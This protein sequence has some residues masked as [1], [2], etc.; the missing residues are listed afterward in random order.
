M[1][2]CAHHV[3]A[4]GHPDAYRSRVMFFDW[5]MGMSDANNGVFLPARVSSHVP[6]L[7][8]AL[9]RSRVASSARQLQA[10]FSID[11]EGV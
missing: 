2:V 8:S 1:D 7:P 3:V 5:G 6:T 10:L 11:L 4:L 9:R